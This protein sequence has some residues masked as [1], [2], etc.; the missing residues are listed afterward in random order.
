MSASFCSWSYYAKL[1]CSIW[2]A[3]TKKTLTSLNSYL[4]N[5]KLKCLCKPAYKVT[6]ILV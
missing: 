5:R 1:V 3:I 4:K 2:D 6:N